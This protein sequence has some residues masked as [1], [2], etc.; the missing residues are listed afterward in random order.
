MSI[1]KSTRHSK[2]VSVFSARAI[3]SQPTKVPTYPISKPYQMEVERLKQRLGSGLRGN[4][5]AN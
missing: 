1:T 5:M 2:I 3:P 4:L